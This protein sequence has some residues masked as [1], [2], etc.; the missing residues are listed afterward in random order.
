MAEKPTEAAV[1]LLRADL[2]SFIDSIER[3]SLD[4][5]IDLALAQLKR[6]L[7]DK[8]GL[9]WNKLYDSDSAAYLST[10]NQDKLQHMIGLLTI[11][12]VFRDY[13]T[14]REG[15]VSGWLDLADRFKADYDD[16]LTNARLD[17][18]EDEDGAI[19]T[20]TEE[21]LSSQGFFRK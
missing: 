8:K 7:E 15:G 4:N 13:G 2:K 3:Q 11:S 1:L 14:A 20:D 5:F 12:L 16:A 6:D 17:I 21:M 9:E 19:D 18:D 10:R